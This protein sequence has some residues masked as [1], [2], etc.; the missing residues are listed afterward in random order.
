[1]GGRPF[2][3]CLVMLVLFGTAAVG[4]PASAAPSQES[5]SATN[6]PAV[7]RDSVVLHVD[8][9]S[10]GTANWRIEYRTRL[11]DPNTTAAFR[12][13]QRDIRDDP[14]AYSRDLFEGIRGTITTA[15]NATG[16]EMAGEQFSVHTEVRRIPREY[17][18][19][20]YTFDW[21]GFAAVDGDRI[22]VGDALSG[23]FLSE[24]E[25]LRLSWSDGYEVTDVL[26]TSDVRRQ[27]AVVWTGTTNFGPDEPRL[28]LSKR[29]GADRWTPWVVAGLAIAVV[30]GGLSWAYRQRDDED[31]ASVARPT[32]RGADLLSNEEQV[33]R[34]L[35]DNGGRIKQQ[36]VA[37]T[38][39]WTEAK[40]SQVITALREEGQI[41]SFRLGR[42]NVLSLS[43]D[44]HT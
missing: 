10:N 33:M 12:S 34:L 44:E 30:G 22:R 17:G 11:D 39:D 28:T 1:M 16:R 13:L 5:Q 3:L 8:V 31:G 18:I 42:E 37:E 21:H 26:P 4:V 6:A 35:K 2:E 29:G 9:R 27:Q 36:D 19:V 38:L 15:E 32:G 24:N 20:V 40:T 41:D 43:D 7:E 14:S 23:F 25:R